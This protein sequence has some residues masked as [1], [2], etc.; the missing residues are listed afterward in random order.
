MDFKGAT[1]LFQDSEFDGEPITATYEPGPDDPIVP[2]GDD[3]VGDTL[4]PEDSGSTPN[5]DANHGGV[6]DP[7]GGQEGEPSGRT[8]YIIDDVKVRTAVERSQYLDEN[9]KL[10]TEDYRV[11]LKD[12]IKK[13][14]LREYATLDL[15][16]IHI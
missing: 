12:E 2:P 6:E 4:P 7:L 16:L 5:M 11:L 15:S 3:D 8:R 10:I 14:L 1:R 13:A 9:G